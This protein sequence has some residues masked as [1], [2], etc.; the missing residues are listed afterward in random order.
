MKVAKADGSV[1]LTFYQQ[2]SLDDELK[3]S[4]INPLFLFVLLS[5][6]DPRMGSLYGSSWAV[7]R[8]TGLPGG[9]VGGGGERAEMR[10]D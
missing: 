3:E 10:E 4:T 1:T 2:I 6:S 9:G 7:I 5:D 8:R